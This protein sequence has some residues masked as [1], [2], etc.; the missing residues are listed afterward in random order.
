MTAAWSRIPPGLNEMDVQVRDILRSPSM[1]AA[2]AA[3]LV[4]GGVLISVDGINIAAAFQ[5]L[6]QGEW[7]GGPYLAAWVA[8]AVY[9]LWVALLFVGARAERAHHEEE[10]I[11]ERKTFERALFRTPNLDVLR[12]YPNVYRR[13]GAA[14][15]DPG[16]KID[17]KTVEAVQ[18]G[19]QD[20]AVERRELLTDALRTVL[21]GVAEL[22]KTFGRRPDEAVYG[23]NIMLVQTP[24][25]EGADRFPCL[26]TRELV[27][28]DRIAGDYGGLRAVLYTVNALTVDT[29]DGEGLAYKR[30]EIAL[31]VPAGS[32]AYQPP[33][34][35]GAPLVFA[36]GNPRVYEDTRKLVEQ[37]RAFSEPVRGAIEAYYS[38]GDVARK[39]DPGAGYR[40]RSF[41]CYRIGT[42]D[43]PIGV[44]NLDC[45]HT[46]L[47]GDEEGY[48]PTFAAL[49]TPILD[50]L[51]E[52]VGAYSWLGRVLTPISAERAAREG[53][54]PKPEIVAG[55]G[56]GD[57]SVLATGSPEAVSSDT[58]LSQQGGTPDD[59]DDAEGQDAADKG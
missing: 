31:P 41:A 1:I 11:A 16:V 9:L 52:P 17:L 46:H 25:G 13:I 4:V 30:T 2:T 10:L 18:G 37:C 48:Y 53:G 3:L 6:Y 27:F 49:L 8:A 23:C 40:V 7:G 34:L 39:V 58:G 22:G 38:A 43:D 36:E 20:I 14:I 55:N 32:G 26:T 29:T 47:L 12:S 51:M 45:D 54:P 56:D 33:F 42:D 28:S 19:A 57:G 50:L 5:R 59:T 44:L 15:R 35:P 24:Q 21:L